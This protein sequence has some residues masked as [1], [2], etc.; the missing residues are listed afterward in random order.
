[1]E[2]EIEQEEV[3]KNPQN[4]VEGET[5]ENSQMPEYVKEIESRNR[6]LW[7]RT[8]KAETM[9]KELETRLVEIEKRVPFTS[10]GASD[11]EVDKILEIKSATE[12]LDTKQINYL[13]DLSKAKRISLTDA[14]QNED[15]GLWN[16]AY[17]IKVEKENIPLPSTTQENARG[18]KNL[19]EMTLD[20]R[21]EYFQKIGLVT[22]QT[23]PKAPRQ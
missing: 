15:F 23:N 17:M 22:K 8:K 18:E 14:R 16:S 21:T 7:E 6:Q 9:N 19:K 1:M 12:G 2:N 20:E 11:T 4:E 13:R 3:L 10:S 5:T